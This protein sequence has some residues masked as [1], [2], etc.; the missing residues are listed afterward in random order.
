MH[1]EIGPNSRTAGRFIVVCYI[2]LP[3]CHFTAGPRVIVTMSNAGA[4]GK[5]ENISRQIYCHQDRKLEYGAAGRYSSIRARAIKKYIAPP[6]NHSTLWLL[7]GIVI[8]PR[9]ADFKRGNSL[10]NIYT[11][12]WYTVLQY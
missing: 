12:A 7:Y 10:L 4:T 8:A 1:F 9:E 3:R 6:I 11:P 2:S 5:Q